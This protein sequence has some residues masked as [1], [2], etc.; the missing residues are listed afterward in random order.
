MQDKF[1]AI[2]VY[3]DDMVIAGNDNQKFSSLNTN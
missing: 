1:T 3:V 2:L